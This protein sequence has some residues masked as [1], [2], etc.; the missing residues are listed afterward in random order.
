MI[1]GNQKPDMINIEPGIF[2]VV[3]NLNALGVN[4]VA[5]C[6][7]HLDHG[8]AGPWVDVESDADTCELENKLDN[9]KIKINSYETN[10]TY[11]NKCDNILKQ[12]HIVLNKLR[13]MHIKQQAKLQELLAD[14]YQ[15]RQVVFDI[16]LH[17]SEIFSDG[18]C[19]LE[20][21]GVNVQEI[22]SL[23]NKAKKLKE[24]QTEMATFGQYL[25]SKSTTCKKRKQ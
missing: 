14:F 8:M 9:L 23:K 18:S 7:G 6:E 12:Y 2:E 3:K 11:G 21:Q 24:Y 1:V 4:T 10:R 19:R 13:R 25:K 5:S 16:R 20:N 22:R 15:N 17:T